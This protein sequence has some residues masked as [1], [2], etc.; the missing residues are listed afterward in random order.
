MLRYNV[1]SGL[2]PIEG[3]RTDSPSRALV[4]NNAV[5]RKGDI[6]PMRAPVIAAETFNAGSRR[7]LEDETTGTLYGGDIDDG[8]CSHQFAAGGLVYAVINGVKSLIQN[9]SVVG[10]FNPHRPDTAPV[11]ATSESL[12]GAQYHIGE[13]LD[14]V[15]ANPSPVTDTQVTEPTAISYQRNVAPVAYEFPV[16][17]IIDAMNHVLD[18]YSLA[19]PDARF[20]PYTF[21]QVIN[22]LINIQDTQPVLSRIFNFSGSTQMRAEPAWSSYS[23]MVPGILAGAINALAFSTYRELTGSWGGGLVIPVVTHI[24]LQLE[25]PEDATLGWVLNVNQLLDINPV[26]AGPYTQAAG[27]VLEFSGGS[28]F[29]LQ[30]IGHYVGGTWRE[31][32]SSAYTPG[33]GSDAVVE[34]FNAVSVE[35]AA[36]RAAPATY[37][38]YGLYSSMLTGATQLKPFTIGVDDLNPN[39]EVYAAPVPRAYC[40]TWFDTFGRESQPSEP[41]TVTGQGDTGSAAIHA[42][43]C[44]GST[45]N[46]ALVGIYRQTVPHDA[47]DVESLAPVWSMVAL[48][49][50]AEAEAGVTIPVGLAGYSALTTIDDAR[51]PDTPRF[52]RI[53]DSGHVVC[54]DGAGTTVYVS[55][56]HKPWAFPYNRRLTIPAGLTALG[57]EVNG[58][59]VYVATNKYLIIYL[60]GEDK[61]DGGLQIEERKL[62]YGNF[63]Y[64]PNTLVSTGWGVMYW[65]R[66]GLI[67]VSG[68]ELTVATA[69]LLDDDQVPA[70]DPVAAVYYDGMYFAFLD[71]GKC[72]VYDVPDPVFKTTVKAPMTTANV[73]ATAA[74]ST[75]AGRLVLAGEGGSA[76]DWDWISGS[77]MSIQYQTSFTRL[78]QDAVFTAAK[79]QGKGVYGVLKCYDGRGLRWSRPLQGDRAVRVPAYRCTGA[80]SLEFTGDCEYISALEISTSMGGLA[81]T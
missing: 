1:F 11:V 53:T 16:A 30:S 66:V 70:Y 78:T 21:R 60:L 31:S 50:P 22:E 43:S 38:W 45:G 40:Y 79:V 33:M 2:A 75:L 23:G 52:M 77:G 64:T 65:S 28:P 20:A 12:L 56:R 61:G 68:V 25:S 32:R 10:T 18:H 58:D 3:E 4:C 51:H 42:V 47:A 5:L 55:K 74:A 27:V 17:T 44:P 37:K 6:R 7:I 8:M 9:G 29:G 62:T 67:A 63:G 76:Y 34:V 19:L 48:V 24:P 35:A 49:P 72:V 46:C 81:N 39:G 15:S 57:I 14:I 69:T 71:D 73:Y 54:T 41:V 80:V 59:T 13:E 26:P 36:C